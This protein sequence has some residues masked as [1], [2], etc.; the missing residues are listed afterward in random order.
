MHPQIEAALTTANHKYPVPSAIALKNAERLLNY[1]EDLNLQRPGKFVPTQSQSFYIL[2]SVEDWE[3]HMECIKTGRI[4]YI[5]S[6]AGHE[7]ASG[8]YPVDE[9]ISQLERYLLIGMG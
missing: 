8:S 5:F 4:I 1:I 6:K 9:F 2:W 7:E 3:F